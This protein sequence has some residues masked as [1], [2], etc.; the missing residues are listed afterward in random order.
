MVVRICFNAEIPNDMYSEMAQIVDHHLE[1]LEF[2]SFPQNY[3]GATM[4]VIDSEEMNEE[5]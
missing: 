4:E 5:D 2:G 1:Y 3:W